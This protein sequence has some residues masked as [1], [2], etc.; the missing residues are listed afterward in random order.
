MFSFPPSSVKLWNNLPS[1]VVQVDSF[2]VFKKCM[3]VFFVGYIIILLAL[4]FVHSFTFF[5]L[6]KKIIIKKKTQVDW[7]HGPCIIVKKK[8]VD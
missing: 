2:A 3:W 4:L 1:D 6:V 7:P 8:I 5:F